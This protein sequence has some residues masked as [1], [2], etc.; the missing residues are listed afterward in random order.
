MFQ[1]YRKIY[2]NLLRFFNSRVARNSPFNIHRD[3]FVF[4]FTGQRGLCSV[5]RSQDRCLSCLC[6]ETFVNYKSFKHKYL[7]G[8][9]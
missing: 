4:G 1:K 7:D 2:R 9:T 5:A 8:L 3:I 6:I